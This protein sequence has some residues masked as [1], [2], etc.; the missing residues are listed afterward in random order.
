MG[1]DSALGRDLD[2]G[3][4]RDLRADVLRDL[5][6]VVFCV[7]STGCAMAGSGSEVA[8]DIGPVLGV[9]C[10]GLEPRSHAGR[11]LAGT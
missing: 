2:G 11:A 7:T 3:V 1:P 10:H 9:P 5:R 8:G 4:L 6:A